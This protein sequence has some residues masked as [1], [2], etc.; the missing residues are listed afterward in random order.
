MPMIGRRDPV[1]SDNR[2]VPAVERPPRRG[3]RPVTG[4]PVLDRAFRLLG[5]FDASRPALALSELSARAAMPASTTLR[6]ARRLV[7]LGA[8][9]RR[10][11]GRFVIGLRML[12]LATLA[13]RGHGIRTLAMPYL[14]DLHRATGHHV[15]LAVRDGDVV[16]LV[17]RLSAAGTPPVMFR[18]G[19]RLPLHA[20]GVGMAVLAHADPLLQEDMLSRQLVLEPER[21]KVDSR[22]LRR[23]LADV[24]REG[25]AVVTRPLPEPA[26]SV[27]A[28]I[29]GAGH[30]VIAAI[31]VLGPTSDLRPS[32]VRA[33][34]FTV[35]R[36][37][38]RLTATLDM[39]HRE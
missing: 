20:T 16:V 3:H 34:V 27:A 29:F 2:L 21:T 28:P 35:A 5:A 36:A 13:P 30:Q 19:E 25:V 38:S 39:G 9:E 4:E 32:R 22:H 26:V 6:L 18:I 37:I 33:A 11:D 31:S 1:I 7:S 14:E 17:E 23:R 10:E 12:E 15:L 24:R 8:L